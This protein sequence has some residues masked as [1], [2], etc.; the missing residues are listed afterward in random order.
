MR[1][2][3]V[4]S[5]AFTLILSVLTSQHRT[6]QDRNRNFIYFGGGGVF[7]RPFPSFSSPP[8]FPLLSSFLRFAASKWPAGPQIQLGPKGLGS[9]VS[10]PGSPVRKNNIAATRHIPWVLSTPQVCLRPIPGRKRIFGVF[11]LR[12]RVWL[13]SYFC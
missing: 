7:S 5:S 6:E 11:E 8:F 2:R 12:E 3:D 4:H 1:H 13:S 9:A 10:S